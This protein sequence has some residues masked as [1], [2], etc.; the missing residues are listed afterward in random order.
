MANCLIFGGAGFIG[1][2]L[3]LY[4]QN[5]NHNITVFDNLSNSVYYN[6]QLLDANK[7]KL[8][9]GPINDKEPLMELLEDTDVIVFGIASQIINDGF[10]NSANLFSD[11]MYLQYLLNVL[12]ETKKTPQYI[13]LL[14][15]INVYGEPKKYRSK[16]S[17]CQECSPINPLG[18]TRL[19]QEIVLKSMCSYLKIPYCIVRFGECHGNNM[20]IF[21]NNSW[22]I[23]NISRIKMG[24]IPFVT[25]DGE[26]TNEFVCVDDLCYYLD[27]II[28]NQPKDLIINIPGHNLK[29]NFIIN[30]IFDYFNVNE[31]DR[32]CTHNPIL[33]PFVFHLQTNPEKI[34]SLFGEH[35]SD[36]DS[37]MSKTINFISDSYDLV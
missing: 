15:D 12:G 8:H 13:I 7:I 5:N 33:Y 17:E 14:S 18:T 35:L 24:Y 2:N 28:E 31:N 29:Y 10:L 37:S 11:V 21:N 16:I 23:S 32:N 36:V 26:H 25:S 19:S 1:T 34:V 9:L 22:L 20:N 27:K 3:S 30:K 4:L 6:Q